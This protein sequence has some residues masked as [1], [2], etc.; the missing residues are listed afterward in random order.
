VTTGGQPGAGRPVAEEALGGSL[1][2]SVIPMDGQ[3]LGQ[4][5]DSLAEVMG[6]ITPGLPVRPQ[7]PRSAPLAQRPGPAGGG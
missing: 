4:L 7:A 2:A 1:W 5:R 6:D 3:N